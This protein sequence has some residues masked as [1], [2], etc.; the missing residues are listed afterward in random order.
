MWDGDTLK[1]NSSSKRLFV[2]NLWLNQ[3]PPANVLVC[4]ANKRRSYV[5][6]L[7][8]PIEEFTRVGACSRKRLT[9]T[10]A[11]RTGGY[12]LDPCDRPV[13]MCCINRSGHRSPPQKTRSDYWSRRW[14]KGTRVHAKKVALNFPS[15]LTL[16]KWYRAALKA[17]WFPSRKTSSQLGQWSEKGLWWAISERNVVI[18]GITRRLVQSIRANVSLLAYQC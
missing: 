1:V 5:T 10:P 15:C 8:K 18:N 4:S 11:L 6:I 9:L 14:R 17:A 2:D 13:V 16:T 3:S 7:P 12:L